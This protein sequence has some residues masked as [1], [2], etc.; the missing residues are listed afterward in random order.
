MLGWSRFEFLSEDLN[1]LRMC[2]ERFDHG[3]RV[4]GGVGVASNVDHGGVGVPQQCQ[5]LG[6]LV[7]EWLLSEALWVGAFGDDDCLGQ[8][9]RTGTTAG[10]F[11]T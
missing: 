1:E 10:M 8:R 3:E 5:N 4:E 6:G 7:E 9:N 2:A 11:G